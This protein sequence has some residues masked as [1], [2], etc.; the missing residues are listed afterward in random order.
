VSTS[1]KTIAPTGRISEAL[2]CVKCGTGLRGLSISATCPECGEPVRSTLQACTLDDP[3]YARRGFE[4]YGMTLKIA[5]VAPAGLPLMAVLGPLVAV[6]L[7]GAGF[8]RVSA[9]G[10]ILRSGMKMSPRMGRVL[11][12]AHVLAWV[13]ACYGALVGLAMVH[14]AIGRWGI[15][16]SPGLAF[17]LVAGWVAALMAEIAIGIVIL[18]RAAPILEVGWFSTITTAATW[19]IAI[20]LVIKLLLEFTPPMGP[21][22]LQGTVQVVFAWI[23]LI[24]GSW[25]IGS[26]MQRLGDVVEDLHWLGAAE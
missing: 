20:G 10:R 19:V 21:P 7:V 17:W 2:D 26:L 25:L 4:D 1:V 23:P 6:V 3:E 22:A 12:L 16:M 18:R 11:G 5:G 15:W 13:V 24:A 9:T 8:V 14:D